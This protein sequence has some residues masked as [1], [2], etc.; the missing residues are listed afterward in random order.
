M[1]VMAVAA[2]AVVEAVEAAVDMAAEIDIRKSAKNRH[3]FKTS[4]HR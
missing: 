1:E 2:E 3:Y 4:L